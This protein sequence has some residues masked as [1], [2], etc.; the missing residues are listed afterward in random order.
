M[1]Q[2]IIHD[3]EDYLTG[4]EENEI[5]YEELTDIFD[6]C[7]IPKYKNYGLFICSGMAVLVD[8]NKDMVF[9][10]LDNDLQEG[11]WRVDDGYCSVQYA[12]I[13]LD[14]MAAAYSW[15]ANRLKECSNMLKR[16]LDSEKF[17]T[18]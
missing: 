12:P 2:K 8:T 9:Y 6:D 13:R 14:L 17:Q 4:L 10:K 18:K 3:V 7:D 15:Y 16:L 11:Q 5:L 1:E